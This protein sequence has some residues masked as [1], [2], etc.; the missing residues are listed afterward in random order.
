MERIFAKSTLR[1]FWEK[2]PDSEQ[3]IKTWYDI[4]MNSNWIN[5]VDVKKH[6][7]RQVFLKTIAL[8]LI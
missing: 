4:A 6:T 1:I 3:F 2:H 7:L 5:P 8:F